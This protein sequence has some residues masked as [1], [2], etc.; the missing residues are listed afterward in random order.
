MNRRF[1]FETELYTRLTCLPLAARHKLD[2]IGIKVSIKQW[3]ALEMNERRTLCEMP[4]ESEQERRTL[5]EFVCGLILQRCGE[6]PAALSLEQQASVIP[7]SQPPT[8][9][10]EQ[11]SALGYELDLTRWKKLDN[12]QRYAL[13]K[14]GGDDRRQA[15]FAAALKEFFG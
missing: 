13:L 3:L 2:M 11:A 10:A 9:I 12:D 1:G 4:A 5:S 8:S 15:K 14:F 6:R 7:P